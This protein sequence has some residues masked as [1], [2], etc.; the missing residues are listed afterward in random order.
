MSSS[1]LAGQTL[2]EEPT[3]FW[4]DVRVTPQE[5]MH[6]QCRKPGQEPTVES[7][8]GP[9]DGSFTIILLNDMESNCPAMVSS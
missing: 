7:L 1:T 2:C 4:L 3:T 5:E 9:T 6:T 8:T